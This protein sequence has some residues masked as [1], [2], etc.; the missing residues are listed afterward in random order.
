MTDLQEMENEIVKAKA[1]LMQA[2]DYLDIAMFALSNVA[3]DSL[4]RRARA[5]NSKA[6]DSCDAALGRL[7]L[8]RK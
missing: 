2:I 7:K 6:A 1:N 4:L 3:L 8:V 5:K